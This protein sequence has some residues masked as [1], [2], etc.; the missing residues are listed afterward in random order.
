M[1]FVNVILLCYTNVD[2]N[3]NPDVVKKYRD[4]LNKIIKEK[5]KK[6]KETERQIRASVN[7]PDSCIL[8]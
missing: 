5:I 2:I 6:D 8:K 7:I 1:S 3:H 4:S